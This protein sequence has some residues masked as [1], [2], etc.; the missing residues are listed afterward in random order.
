MI[1][2]HEITYIENNM[3]VLQFVFSICG[4]SAL[5]ILLN[6]IKVN[7]DSI[8]NLKNP[9]QYSQTD[10]L[11]PFLNKKNGFQPYII[12]ERLTILP[13]KIPSNCHKTP[14]INAAEMNIMLSTAGDHMS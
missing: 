7:A 11:N 1:D 4:K 10:F 13:N 6:I 5:F 2:I 9:N 8:V 14:P 12:V 3:N